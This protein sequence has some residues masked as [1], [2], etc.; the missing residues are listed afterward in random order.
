M[1]RQIQ[2][3]GLDPT[4]CRFQMV[5]LG[6]LFP[7]QRSMES[8]SP[9]RDKV[10]ALEREIASFL[11]RRHYSVLGTHGRSMRLQARLFARVRALVAR[12]FPPQT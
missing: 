1:T 10:A 11:R 6:P 2:R 3:A 4:R 5:A 9:I 7:E 8:H 12:E